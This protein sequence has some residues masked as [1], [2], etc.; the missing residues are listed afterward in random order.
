MYLDNR[1]FMYLDNRI[2]GT[3]NKCRLLWS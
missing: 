2:L 3:S 1:I